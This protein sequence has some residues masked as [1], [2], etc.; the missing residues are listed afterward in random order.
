MIY[1]R[2]IK[3]GT[4][5]DNYMAD[6]RE[7]E[8]WIQLGILCVSII[9]G[10]NNCLYVLSQCSQYTYRIYHLSNDS[11]LDYSIAMFYV[12]VVLQSVSC[13]VSLS[14]HRS[15]SDDNT[16]VWIKHKR[17]IRSITILQSKY[18]VLVKTRKLIYYSPHSTSYQLPATYC[19]PLATSIIIFCF[20]FFFVGE[21][22]AAHLTSVIWFV[23]FYSYFI[24]YF[25]PCSR[26]LGCSAITTPFLFLFLLYFH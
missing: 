24:W 26:A 7:K 15:I 25:M 20:H 13:L 6:N 3:K 1:C 17:I 11:L 12:F 8:E 2:N 14:L 21:F 22:R 9:K 4:K 18:F 16:L 19:R 10:Q 5:R 23:F